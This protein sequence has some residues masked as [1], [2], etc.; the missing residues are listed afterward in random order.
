M[1]K[2]RQ[3]MMWR[4]VGR[5]VRKRERDIKKQRERER[6]EGRESQTHRR[7]AEKEKEFCGLGLVEFPFFYWSCRRHIPPLRVCSG[8][9]NV[10]G[11]S[12]KMDAIPEFAGGAFR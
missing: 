12:C 4:V 3:K 5:A 7:R 8:Q 10:G 1:G 11:R 6:K 2:A 9:L